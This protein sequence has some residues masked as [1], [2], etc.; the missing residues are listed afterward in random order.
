MRVPHKTKEWKMVTEIIELK[1]AYL[2]NN[3]QRKFILN[4]FKYLDP[5]LPFL[6]QKGLKELRWLNYIHA[7]FVKNDDELANEWRF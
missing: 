1:D 2:L 4:L 6:D 7:K 3:N 5:H